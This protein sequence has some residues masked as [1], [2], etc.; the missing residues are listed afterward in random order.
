MFYDFFLI[1]M[2]LMRNQNWK[3]FWNHL[4]TVLSQGQTFEVEFEA[5]ITNIA[6][7][8]EW[9]WKSIFAERTEKKQQRLFLLEVFEQISRFPFYLNLAI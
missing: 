2:I 6:D 8:F 3:M 1:M 9:C 7:R 4:T 5:M